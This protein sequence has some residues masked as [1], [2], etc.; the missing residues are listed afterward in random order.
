MAVSCPDCGSPME[1]GFLVDHG[2]SE[3]ARPGS[4]IEGVPE[5]AKFLGMKVGLKL[6]GKRRI[7]ITALR[8]RR[9]GVLKLYA[10]E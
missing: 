7:E 9:C 2:E 6:K 8:C 3:V 10:R 5:A 1:A 4:W